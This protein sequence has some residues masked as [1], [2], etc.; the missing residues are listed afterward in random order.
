MIKWI[1]KNWPLVAIWFVCIFLIYA[2]SESCIDTL[3]Y[4]KQ[5]RQL[6]KSISEKQKNIEDSEVVI[7]K[8]RNG[9]SER[10][11]SIAK[12]DGLIREKDGEIAV[13]R[14]EKDAWK[15]KVEEMTPSEVVINTR[16][17][18]NCANIFERP[19]GVLFT[20]ACA[21]VNLQALRTGEFSF[22]NEEVKKL[23][24]KV[25]DM[26]AKDLMKDTQILDLESVILLK[27]KQIIGLKGV[28]K[29]WKEEFDLSEGRNKKARKKGR[30][31]GSIVGFI[32]GLVG[33]I[34]L[35]K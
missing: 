25:T 12:R 32:I 9:I 33:G 23:E 26:T 10:D 8:L 27:D 7:G 4:K 35:G 21:R 3:N 15:G 24:E 17:V 30:K 1:K 16:K 34:L 31:E 18:L 19:D 5:I 22:A 29:D 14:K 11:E 6:N 13:I 20:L 2:T 28:I